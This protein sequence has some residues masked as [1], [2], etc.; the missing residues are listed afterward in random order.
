MLR[1]RSATRAELLA[2]EGT[3]VRKLQIMFGDWWRHYATPYEFRWTLYFE[4]PSCP[5]CGKVRDIDIVDRGDAEAG[6]WEAHLD[7][8]DPLSRGGEDSLRN[9]VCTCA[10]CNVTKGRR[11]FVAWLDMLTPDRIRHARHLYEAK[12][13]Q[14]PEAFQPGL[15]QARL[16]Q[17]RRE[18]QLDE[19]VLRRLFPRPI[20]DGPPR[21]MISAGQAMPKPRSSR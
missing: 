12:H 15:R 6:F 20:V 3:K 13:G 17:P 18:L 11:L 1:E 5:Y 4:E 7:H 9:V 8:M 14:P 2:Y 16:V 19:S 10:Q 21:T